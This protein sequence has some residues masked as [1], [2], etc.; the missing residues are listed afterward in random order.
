[1][2]HAVMKLDMNIFKN[3]IY[4]FDKQFGICEWMADL[5]LQLENYIVEN[6]IDTYKDISNC[7][8]YPLSDSY[9]QYDDPFDQ[10][11]NET[12]PYLDDL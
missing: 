10:L 8:T 4:T 3:A 1:M 7:L 12:A 9:C 5:L 6:E 2:I 11:P